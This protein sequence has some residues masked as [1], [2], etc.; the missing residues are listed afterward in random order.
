MDRK[1]MSRSEAGRL[2]GEATA[3]KFDALTRCPCCGRP[4]PTHYFQD[5]GAR[6]GAIG[7]QVTLRRYGVKHMTEIGRRGGRPRRRP[8]DAEK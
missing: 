2:G 3:F 4:V 6:G 1:R 5:L 7:G 8:P